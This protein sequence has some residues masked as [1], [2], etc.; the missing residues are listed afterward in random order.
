ME[1]DVRSVPRIRTP[2]SILLDIAVPCGEE[3]QEAYLNTCYDQFKANREINA[4]GGM[5]WSQKAVAIIV[6]AS[7]ACSRDAKNGGFCGGKE[8][9][10]PLPRSPKRQIF[11]AIPLV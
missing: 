6:S 8:G 4:N 10:D 1:A 9:S 11:R 7:S 2:P 5:K 3:P